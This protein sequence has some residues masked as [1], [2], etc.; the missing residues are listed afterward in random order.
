MLTLKDRRGIVYLTNQY[1]SVGRVSRQT[2]ADGTTYQFAYTLDT[3][4][5]VIQTAVTDPASHLRRAAFND[6]G[7]CTSDTKALGLPEQQP[8][9]YARQAGSNFLTSVTDA[10]ERRT[11]YTYDGL[12]NVTSVQ[13]LAGPS[14]TPPPGRWSR[15]PTRSARPRTSGTRAVIW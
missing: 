13:R 3:A 11:A 1:D 7:Y 15:R 6:D 5:K 14:P 4:G 9:T 12:G 10:L 2:Q 8:V